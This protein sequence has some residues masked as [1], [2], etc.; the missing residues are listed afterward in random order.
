ML[1]EYFSSNYATLLLIS[2]IIV[3]M[4]VNKS[5]E[6]PATDLFIL[7]ISLLLIITVFDTVGYI[8][9]TDSPAL[10]LDLEGRV[11]LR[12]ISS[13]INYILR[14]FVIM[15]EILIIIPSEA[16]LKPL[17]AIPAAI[18]LI[19]YS[20]AFMGS[21]IAYEITPDNH[22]SRG[23]L[24]ISIFITLHFYVFLLLA[25]SVKYFR[26]LSAGKNAIVILIITQTVLTSVLEY[27]NL[28]TGFSSFLTALAVLEYYIYLSVIY[29]QDIRN[30]ITQKELDLEKE[31]M[32]LLRNQ[33]HPHFIYNS[34][35]II[36]SLAKR[37]SVRAVDCID[38][39][40]DYLK[41]HIGA[42]EHDELISFEQELENVRIYLDL[43]RA[44][45]ARHLEVIYD[46]NTGDF[47]L[48]PLSLE[49][50]VENAVNH[51]VSRDSGVITV[52]SFET[53]ECY[54]IKITDNG[55]AKH[56]PQDNVPFHMGVGIENTRR[57]LDMQ[58]G[59][60]LEMDMREDGTTVTVTIPKKKVT[61]N[62]SAY[63]G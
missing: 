21:N 54:L 16:K 7:T 45:K 37:D 55:T 32:L 50:I 59:G 18:N 41:A 39:F 17:A 51:G 35:S 19:I 30:K 25:I 22:F 40:S 26:K 31:K 6:I 33:I 58:C 36:R 52:S 1:F 47:R 62:E 48:P 53:E 4:F 24:G 11:W 13:A 43:V 8:C 2:A 49:P 29:Q 38:N 57:R 28:I 63:S 15:T 56:S 5:Y 60:T 34:L 61:E 23:P 12:N 14:P 44:D 3:I 42:I 20:T 27:T 10:T 9:E 46:L